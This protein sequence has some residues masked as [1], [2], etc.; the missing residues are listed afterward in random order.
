MKSLSAKRLIFSVVVVLLVV[1]GTL[2]LL[3]NLELLPCNLKCRYEEPV[4]CSAPGCGG[5][6]M[7]CV[8]ECTGIVGSWLSPNCFIHEDIKYCTSNGF[9]E[10]LI[11]TKMWL[12]I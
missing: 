11:K 3:Y 1:L 7:Q 8:D 10:T 5:S 2:I 12:G 4:T 9:E 6:R